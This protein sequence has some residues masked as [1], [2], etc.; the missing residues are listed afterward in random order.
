[1]GGHGDYYKG[2]KY[3]TKKQY[4]RLGVPKDAKNLT[5]TVIGG[6]YRITWEEE[7]NGVTVIR[8]RWEKKKEIVRK[9]RS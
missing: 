1:M 8:T 6:I 2:A 5:R 3:L 4:Q 7:V 9:K